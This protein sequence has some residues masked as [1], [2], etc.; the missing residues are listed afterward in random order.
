MSFYP[1]F[2]RWV[3]LEHYRGFKLP[4]K[5]DR[6]KEWLEIVQQHLAVRSTAQPP[7]FYIQDYDRYASNKASGATAEEMRRY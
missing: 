5:C 3:A 6:L 4:A 7:E 2:D 1:W